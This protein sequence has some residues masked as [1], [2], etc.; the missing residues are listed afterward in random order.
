MKIPQFQY[1][2]K[3]QSNYCDD[4]RRPRRDAPAALQLPENSNPALK[5]PLCGWQSYLYI[6]IVR[7]RTPFM[8]VLSGPYIMYTS[9]LPGS[10][11]RKLHMYQE[12]EDYDYD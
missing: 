5:R 9:V 4:L 7:V 12:N 8:P 1:F 6:F 11:M 3:W 10:G 2:G